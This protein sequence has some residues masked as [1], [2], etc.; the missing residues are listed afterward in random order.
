MQ[1][2]SRLV[3]TEGVTEDLFNAISIYV[4]QALASENISSAAYTPMTEQEAY[5]VIPVT[6]DNYK[7]VLKG[8]LLKQWAS[9]FNDDTNFNAKLYIIIFKDGSETQDPWNLWFVADDTEGFYMPTM[10]KAFQ[11]TYFI[12]YF[13][14]M[15]SEHYNGKEVTGQTTGN[16]DDT[17]YFDEALALAQLCSNEN[18]LSQ[19]VFFVHM[20]SDEINSESA[21][22][23]I[24]IVDAAIEKRNAEHATD[25]TVETRRQYFWGFLFNYASK[26][27]VIFHTEGN[28][29]PTVLGR[30][31]E[32]KNETGNFVGN[33]LA[34]IR[35]TGSKV[36]PTGIPSPL[37]SEVN[38]NIENYNESYTGG[39]AVRDNLDEKNVG[40]F[41][42]IAN[43]SDSNSELI[44][45]NTV[46]GTPV[47]A[48]QLSKWIDYNASQAM[49]KY[50]TAISTLTH[51]VLANQET[52]SRL[53]EILVNTIS[54]FAAN[55]RIT[56]VQVNFPPFSEAKKGNWFEG[57]AVWSALYVGELEGVKIS[58]TI[59]F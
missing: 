46:D 27:Q 53:Q 25:S 43:D 24:T 38:C 49:A 13:K 23:Y 14:T 42:S 3:E 34:K 20:E 16:Y 47:T 36:K 15:F 39:Y 17:H 26:A 1:F 30:W 2:R 22:M 40:Y 57:T 33:K 50:A 28:L 52:Y 29:L 21:P 4:P 32:E 44:S 59:S 51:P 8:E 18:T 41:I 7:T 55:G 9:V 11:N 5:A 56:N 45:A 48:L 12:S 19:G 37:N 6:V 54:V 58:G 31:F 35:L 10:T